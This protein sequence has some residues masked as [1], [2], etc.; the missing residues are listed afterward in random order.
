[1]DR[2]I[3][4]KNAHQVTMRQKVGTAQ[5][6]YLS[7]PQN[8][9]LGAG[10]AF[11]NTSTIQR[12]I[13]I[14]TL[15]IDGT[16]DQGDITEITI[17]GLSLFVSD[18]SACLAAFSSKSFGSRNRSVGVS[19]LNNQTVVVQGSLVNGGNVGV[20]IA[21]DPL[22]AR[23]VKSPANQAKAYNFVFGLGTVSIPAG[24]VNTASL[25]S[26]ELRPE[27]CRYR[28]AG[29]SMLCGQ[30]GAQQIPLT[31]LEHSSSDLLGLKLSYPIEA[32]AR[33]EVVLRNYDGANAC[34][35]SGAILIE[36]WK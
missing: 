12:P 33:V 19:A 22:E 4:F 10:A 36:P 20:A 25:I 30:T 18:Q 17:A 34:Q 11:T 35:V 7:S 32:N 23:S 2:P 9:G 24:G 13:L 5:N 26:A 6:L 16:D 21:V 1:M 31:A 27:L 28:V 14:Q 8:R 3:M 15:N 29:L